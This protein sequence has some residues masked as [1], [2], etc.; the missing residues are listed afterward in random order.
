MKNKNAYYSDNNEQLQKIKKEFDNFNEEILIM[1]M[2]QLLNLYI[3][4]KKIL[5]F[6]NSNKINNIWKIWIP[7]IQIII[8]TIEQ[9]IRQQ[10]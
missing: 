10:N 7:I 6:N 8:Y 3:K 1:K 5:F 4:I 9:I 2:E